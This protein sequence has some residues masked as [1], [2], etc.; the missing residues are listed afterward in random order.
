MKYVEELLWILDEPGGMART[1][2]AQEKTFQ[3][4]REFVHGLGLKCD[5]VGWCKLD[6]SNPR[7][8][9]ILDQISLFCK[10]NGWRVRG[11]YTRRYVDLESDWYELVPSDFKDNT[12][13]DRIEAVTETGEIIK[14]CVIRA[15]HEIT[16]TPKTW[17]SALFVPARFR[18]FCLH[19]GNDDLDF[20]WARDTGKYQAEQYFHVYGKRLIPKIAADFE[21]NGTNRKGIAE[22]G[23]WLPKIA[24]VFHT[25]QQVNL[26]D[27]YLRTDLPEAGF[28][29]AYIPTMYGNARRNT[30]LIHKDMAQRML[31]QKIIPASALRPAPVVEE[32]PGG[33]AWEKTSP[34][35]CPSQNFIAQMLLE[36][37][38]QKSMN[39]PV[40]VVTEKEALKILRSA[41][42]ERKGDF[43]KAMPKAKGQEL[44]ETA[45]G[46]V[47]PY[48]L[49]ANG[50]HL[51]D[52]YEFLPYVRA[53]QETDEFF[54]NLE[55]E[56]LLD[57]K[58]EGVV[59][60]KCSDGDLIL[61][62]S[63]GAVIRFSH[64]VPEVTEEW[65]SLAQFIVDAIN[66]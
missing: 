40:R 34:A 43:Q 33:Y 54:R 20:C 55:A 39:R 29:Y 19:N 16:P 61:L 38:Q 27:C 45:Y 50:G 42:K 32:L 23:G 10:E 24:G 65:I 25:L 31:T 9:E 30:I 3:I 26:P 11:L 4:R 18:D 17:G 15:Y 64:E 48:Y 62:C 36:Y 21:L 5:C 51:S 52:E 35:A 57:E 49:A 28:V 1:L 12:M 2:E 44:L 41:K 6:L 13:A 58:P 7:T 59:I 66:N 8:S 60:A 53:A 56:E 14:T 46:S 37:E 47:V 22:S 63:N